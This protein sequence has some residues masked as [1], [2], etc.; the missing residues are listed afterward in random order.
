[1]IKLIKVNKQD[2]LEKSIFII[3]L[4]VMPFAVNATGTYYTG[5]YQSTK[6]RYTQANFATCQI[7]RTWFANST[8]PPLLLLQIIINQNL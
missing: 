5:N 8:W 1:M 4:I 2:N 7:S 6:Y 3:S